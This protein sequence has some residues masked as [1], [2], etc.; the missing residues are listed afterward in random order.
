MK[1]SVTKV[2]IIG[3]GITGLVAAYELTQAGNRVTLV[4][5]EDQ[6]GGQGAFFQSGENWI[7]KF[8]H[9]QMPS[10]DYLLKLISDVGLKGRMSWR[11]TRM[12]FIVDGIRYPFNTPFDV[13]CF[14][15]LS[16]IHRLR[17]GI[18]SLFIRRIGK[19]M[20]LDNIRIEDWFC[21]LYSKE[22][23]D[24]ILKPLFCSKF[25]AYGGNLPALYIWQRLG[26]ESNV[27][28]RGYI[29]GGMK[30]LIDSIESKI[31]AFGGTVLTQSPAKKINERNDKMVVTLDDGKSIECDWV[32]STI[33]IPLLKKI[34]I[35]GTL[36]QKFRG[37]DL[38]YISVINALFLLS[39]PLDKFY[40]S[41]VINSGTEFDGIVEMSELVEKS[42]YSGR[43]AVYVMK[44]CDRDSNL[45]NEDENQIGQRWAD[46]LVGLYSD[47][48]L[49]NEDIEETHVFKSPFIEPIYQPGYSKIKPDSRVG[50]SKLLLATTAQIYPNITSCNTCVK[51]ASETVSFLKYTD[52]SVK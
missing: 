5:A 42:Q 48:K 11:S 47:I 23:W 10:D 29:Y 12:G 50:D 17:F 45:F 52:R 7:D 2:V 38:S 41:P 43:H 13:L 6:L 22:V 35:G 34:I 16:F 27:A 15:P 19:G 40:W 36:E 39:R 26:R 46:Q 4:E 14:K 1:G 24:R 9:C 49:K 33:A 25:G 18:V 28:K 37:P 21:K 30:S 32:I 20:D 44:Y 31:K 51:L 3:G 8:Y